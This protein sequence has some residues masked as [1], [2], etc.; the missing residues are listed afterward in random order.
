MGQ[1][2]KPGSSNVST[3]SVPDRF[4]QQVEVDLMEI[5]HIIDQQHHR[6]LHVVDRCTRWQ[7]TTEVPNKEEDTLLFAMERI[8]IGIYGPPEE[9]IVDGEGGIALSESTRS[10]LSRH[11]ISLHVRAKD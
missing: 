9:L 3:T 7:A 8:W 10:R 2:A 11:G 1:A 4:N 6:I 5:N